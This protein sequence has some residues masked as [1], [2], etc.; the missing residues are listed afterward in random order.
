M[1]KTSKTVPQ[2]EAASSSR[3]ASD[4]AAAEPHPE[5]FIP[6]GCPTVADFKIEKT[7][8][9]PGRC[10]PVSRYIC[11]IIDD[12]LTKVKED[13]NWVDKHVVVP[14]PEESI[15]THVEGFLSVYTYPFTLGHLDPIIIAFCKSR[16][17]IV[18][19]S[20]VGL[21]KDVAMRPLSG[22]EDVPL[23]SPALKQGDEKKRKRVPSSPN[24]EKKK[25]KKRSR[26]PKGS[27]D[28]LSLDSIHRLRDESEE[29]EEKSQ[30]V[31]RVRTGVVMQGSSEPADA[32]IGLS[33][34]EEVDEG[35]LAEAPKP[36]GVEATPPQAKGVE[37]ETGGDASRIEEGI[38]RDELRVID[39]TGSPQILDAMIRE[40]GMLE[41]RSYEGPQGAIDIHHFLDRFESTAFEDI[42]GLGD[43]PVP[44]KASVLHHETFLRYREEL[45]H[46]EAEVWDLTEKSDTYKLLSEKLQAD[47]VQ[48]RLEQI[49]ELQAQVDTIQAEAEEFK[50][51][52][53]I[54]ASKREA[55]QAQLE[56][57][58][59]HIRATKEK[60]SVQVKKIEELQSQLDLAISDK[61]NLSNEL[62]AAKSEVVVANTKAD[63]KVSQFKVDVEAIQAQAKNMVDHA[64][65]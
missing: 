7:S 60:A 65:W 49:G 10:E 52:I 40:A 48:Q 3:P 13:C 39:I 18:L 17:L 15:T 56:S 29:E 41:S 27:T 63:A 33:R 42:T 47:L 53:D 12:L 23:K 11:T 55:A 9:V 58:E 46:H 34:H 44:N 64:R 6:A 36:E 31:T 32:E 26:K 14:S 21:P 50:K 28:A 19:F 25:P 62:E 20:F 51:N 38:P 61:A 8:S 30:L 45:T 37:R 16:I 2:K 4:G 1:A 43:L 35:V 5:E 22:E 24:S 57:A 59:T 54:F